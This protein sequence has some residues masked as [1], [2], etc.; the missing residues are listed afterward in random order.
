M[1]VR[2]LHPLFKV[3]LEFRFDARKNSSDKKTIREV[4]EDKIYIKPSIEFTVE[5]EDRW[6]DLGGNIGAFSV[7]AGA[8]AKEVICFEAEPNNCKIITANLSKNDLL[9]KV[10]V[11]HA[12]VVP[13]SH[14]A[15]SV[16]LNVCTKPEHFWMHTIMASTKESRFLQ[17]PAVP[18][19]DVLT[20]GVDCIKMDIEG[21]EIPILREKPSLKTIRKLVFEWS[22]DKDPR[23]KVLK[24]VLEYLRTEFDVVSGRQLPEFTDIWNRYPPATNYF[25]L[26]NRV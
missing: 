1:E 5:P 4:F 2:A 23:I 9:S 7:L 16:N 25:C 10:T 21:A 3:P 15:K 26:K 20:A 22:F 13:N 18:F 19:S 11:R 14:K 12:A 6:A 8:I 17:V 24:E